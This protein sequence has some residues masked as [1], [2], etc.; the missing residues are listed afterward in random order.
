M[1]LRDAPIPVR[2]AFQGWPV[3]VAAMILGFWFA[4][5]AIM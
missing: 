1:E 4:T 2:V 3:I 5:P